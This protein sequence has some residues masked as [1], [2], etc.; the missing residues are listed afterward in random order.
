MTVLLC[1]IAGFAL[2]GVWFACCARLQVW[3][4]K[5]P[6]AAQLAPA[7]AA[8]PFLAG[9]ALTS[10]FVP[11]TWDVQTLLRSGGA[12]CA[13][14]VSAAAITSLCIPRKRLSGR[15]LFG[16]CLGGLL[17]ELPQRLMMQSALFALMQLGGVPDAA[18][19]VVLCCAA[20][21]CF[22]I[23]T[24]A[25]LTKQTLDRALFA[26]LA[27]SLVFSIGL[28]YAYQQ[29]GLLALSMAAH[30]AERLLGN[31]LARGKL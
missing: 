4:K 7:L 1:L 18:R 12:A 6:W 21:W 29:T 5:W 28:G 8:A 31:A 24:Q 13:A 15:A 20:V 3:L 27:A 14:A 11:H 2:C 19:W 10:G 9:L 23:V 17:M 22:G 16:W 25:M 30:G 26:E